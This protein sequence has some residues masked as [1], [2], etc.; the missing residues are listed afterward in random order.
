[1]FLNCSGTSDTRS[2]CLIV[3]AANASGVSLLSVLIAALWRDTATSVSA[4][5]SSRLMRLQVP[6]IALVP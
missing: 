1:V 2:S 4:T 5:R 3:G 6:S